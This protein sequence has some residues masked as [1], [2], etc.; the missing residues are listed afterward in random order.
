MGY[1]DGR[2]A[3]WRHDHPHAEPGGVEQA[4]CEVEGHPDAA[5]RRWISWQDAAMERDARP[6]DAL[7]VGHIGIVINVG[8]VLRFSLYDAKDP[9]GCFASLLAAR[10][11]RPQDPAVGVVDGDPLVVERNDRHDW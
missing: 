4:R 5:M 6:G 2:H 7:H 11:R 3:G 10:H 9:G 1:L 8:V